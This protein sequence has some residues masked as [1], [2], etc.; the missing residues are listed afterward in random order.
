[1]YVG[2]RAWRC[3]Y[4][5]VC[6]CMCVCACAC[7][8]V[9]CVCVCVCVCMCVCMCVCGNT[10]LCDVSSVVVYKVVVEHALRTHS[11]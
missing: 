10:G 4:V 6:I 9:V 3:A 1:M 5:Y 11:L 7:V 2:V 8:C